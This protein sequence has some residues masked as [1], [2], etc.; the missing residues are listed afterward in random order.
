MQSIELEVNIFDSEL[1][2]FDLFQYSSYIVQ[3]RGN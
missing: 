2:L 3:K 1:S